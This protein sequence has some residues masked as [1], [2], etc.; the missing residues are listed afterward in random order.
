MDV[1]VDIEYASDGKV[2]DL[3]QCRPKA[4]YKDSGS[5]KLPATITPVDILFETNHQGATA[6]VEDITHVVYVSPEDYCRMPN[7][8]NYVAVADAIRTLNETLAPRSFILIGPGRWGTRDDPALGVPVGFAAISQTA[9]LVEVAD[10]RAGRVPEPSHGTH[11]FN[12][13]VESDIRCLA[14][15]PGEEGNVFNASFLEGA[16]NSLAELLPEHAA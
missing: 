10:P 2:L 9:L 12:D 4:Q 8:S 14:I 11:F 6:S 13:L 15:F 3:L 16:P 1:P 7:R 5:I